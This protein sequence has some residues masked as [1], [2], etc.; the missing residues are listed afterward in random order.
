MKNIHVAVASG[1]FFELSMEEQLALFE[2]LTFVFTMQRAG[3]DF[4]DTD[5]MILLESIFKENYN[6]AARGL[7]VAE[8]ESLHEALLQSRAFRDLTD[9]VE[10][11]KPKDVDAK[12]T[13]GDEDPEEEG[14]DAEK[15]DD[16]DEKK[17]DKDAEK[18]PKVDAEKKKGPTEAQMQ[19]L[20][21]D[22]LKDTQSKA[23][24]RMDADKKRKSAK[25]SR[26]PDEEEDEDDR[27]DTELKNIFKRNSRGVWFGGA[28]VA[29]FILSLMAERESRARR[30]GNS[31]E[32]FLK[33]YMAGGYVEHIEVHNHTV[34]AFL[35]EGV[36][37]D[38]HVIF[39]R[40]TFD[41]VS[42]LDFAQ[43]L[44]QDCKALNIREVPVIGVSE[45]PTLGFVASL[46]PMVVLFWLI[47][48]MSKGSSGLLKGMRNPF[49]QK[50]KFN[51]VK[52]V[53][54]RFRD[55][56]G[57]EESKREIMEFVD[58]LKNPERYQK[59]GAKLPKGALLSGPPGTG[60]TLLARA[61]AGESGVPFFSTSGSEFQE[62]FVGVGASRVR[63]LFE[64]ARKH[65]PSI[66]FIDEIDAI[67]RA[68]SSGRH[69]GGN[70]EREATLNQ[71]LVEM[72]GF[73]TGIP[74]VVLAG[75]NRS[76]MLD[77]AI[78]RS[79]RFDRKI[80]V[81]APDIKGRAEI[82]LVHLRSIVTNVDKNEVASKLAA[83][84][85]GMVGADI[86]N[87]CNEAAI[88]AARDKA[89]SV[90][91]VHFEKAIDRMI[92]GLEK[93]NH[94]LTAEERRTVAYHEAGH[95]VVGWMLEYA[96]PLLKVTIVPR[97]NGALG[98]AQYL[99][100]ESSLYSTDAL[101]DMICMALGGRAAEQ[102]FF[103]RITTGASDDIRRTTSI[104][105]GMVTK[106]GM[107]QELYNLYLHNE[108]DS[109]IASY[110]DATGQV[111]DTATKHIIDTQ[112]QRCLD[113]VE[114]NRDKIEKLAEALLEH[115]TINHDGLVEILGER[116]VQSD[117]YV[118]YLEAQR[119]AV[120]ELDEAARKKQQEEVAAERAKEAEMAEK[121]RKSTSE[122]SNKKEEDDK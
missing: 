25:D 57:L 27:S 100:R 101:C 60:K 114:A 102:T 93:K 73:K 33:K 54:T 1:K 106:Y 30:R 22:I 64:T 55:V 36:P 35:R 95:A 109:M 59:L 75:T 61:T 8:L 46:L 105:K 3:I 112:Y 44:R 99:P 119:Q 56:A 77:P 32:I 13:S 90:E 52:D 89:D 107:S 108:N 11:K 63:D 118:K 20:W 39:H 79:G 62:M 120:Q 41:F 43:R 16:K 98:F 87:V 28:L 34:T 12:K 14:K 76:D 71:M 21:D 15:K 91:L 53:K 19:R 86:A 66:I 45:S 9:K 47:N 65:A 103:K 51:M 104:A 83:L 18:A 121:E 5:K 48:S 111:I 24:K 69:G 92:A 88:F 6:L 97:S 117:A 72:D 49:S 85:P 81:D 94:I 113:V 82:F 78:T 122:V 96:E 38:E 31:Y 58:F 68:R 37:E 26:D 67:A 80:T 84:T 4:S 70:D 74:V 10:G 17:D 29:L 50:K 115:E 2:P 23:S 40:Y 110:S 7:P 116:A 42:E